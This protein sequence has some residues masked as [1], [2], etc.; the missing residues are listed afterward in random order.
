MRSP[1]KIE[2]KILEVKDDKQ[3]YDT[4][5]KVKY[6]PDLDVD[7]IRTVLKPKDHEKG[8][9]PNPCLSL[10]RTDN[11]AKRLVRA[12]LKECPDP[13]KSNNPMTIKITKPRSGNS[14]PCGNPGC[15]CCTSISMKCRV[16]STHNNKTYPTQRFTCCATR[17]IIYLIECTRCTKGNQ[18]IGHTTTPLRTQLAKHISEEST[19]KVNVPLYKHFLQKT[20]H[21]FKRDTMQDHY[22]ASNYQTPL[23]GKRK[24]L[25]TIHPNGLNNTNS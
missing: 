22:S 17:N 14:M 21:D 23:L 24:K 2:P 18:Y 4:F 1:L 8:K 5:L 10:S 7:S 13:P 16:T 3:T 19:I 6:S 12:K 20:G 15:K 25:E 11:I 9:V